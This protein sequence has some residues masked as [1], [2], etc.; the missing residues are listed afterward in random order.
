MNTVDRAVVFGKFWPLHLGHAD[1]LR[2]AAES[3]RQLHVF[4]D[5]GSEDVPAAERMAWV[6]ELVPQSVVAS[7]PDLCGH[8]SEYCTPE[9][10]KRY[11]QFLRSAGVNP[12]VIFAADSYG[13]TLA[14]ELNAA[15]VRLEKR[16][17]CRGREIRA[18]IPRNWSKLS[19]PAREYYCARVVVVGAES[20]GTTT[21][22]RHLAAALETVCVPEYGRTFTE[23][24]G[25]DHPWN[26]GDFENIARQQTS[27]ID[28][29]CRG[30]QPVIVADTDALATAIWHER[31]M[32]APAP[33]SIWRKAALR[34]PRI[35]L[36]TGPEIPFVQD[37]WRDGEH[38]R[39]WM[40]QRFRE[41]LEHTGSPWV[42][43]RG[44]PATRL[45]T[46]VNVVRETLGANWLISRR[47]GLPES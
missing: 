40:T 17:G 27:G 34:P 45:A 36:L 32:K 14:R 3:A 9:C 22:A 29:A 41:Q 30:E 20:T 16:P 46:A 44:D 12:D 6:R 11:A 24:H 33:P 37:G 25:L 21:L 31:Y 28:Q 19:D 8:E 5:D 1:L 10:S 13:E 35:Y 43:V 23:E 18:D 47:S 26:S 4:V 7:S 38:V 2:R 15:N 42:E 39:E